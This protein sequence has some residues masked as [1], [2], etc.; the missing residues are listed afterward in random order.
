MQPGYGGGIVQLIGGLAARTRTPSRAG[1]DRAR[2]F[3]LPVVLV[4]LMV[5]TV[6]AALLIRRGTLDERMAAGTRATVTVDTAATYALRYCERW[7]LL[8]PPGLEPLPG[9]PAPPQSVSSPPAA[10]PPAWRQP[11]LWSAAVT[12][13]PSDLGAEVQSARCLIEEATGELE[14]MPTDPAN[15]AGLRL[16]DNFRKYRLT[17]EVQGAGLWSGM[18]SHA[19]S[20][21]RVFVT[22]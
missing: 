13:N 16:E 1:A 17:V 4:M 5:L 15:N 8:S 7:V 3:V 10:G 19:Q 2:G 11:S 21:L 14:T 22:N 20:E 12:L 18:V 9:R 6:V